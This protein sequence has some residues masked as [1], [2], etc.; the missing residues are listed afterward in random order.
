MRSAVTFGISIFAALALVACKGRVSD[1]GSVGRTPAIASASTSSITPVVSSNAPAAPRGSAASLANEYRGTIGS[2]AIVAR[3]HHDTGKIHGAYFYEKNGV[4]LDLTGT[5][6]GAHLTLDEHAA[7]E[8]T[9]ALSGDVA[10]DGSITGTWSNS[11]ADKTLPLTLAP[12]ASETSPKTALL[13]KKKIAITK[14]V[15]GSTSKEDV[16]KASLEYAEVF[17]LAPD[18]E[19]KINSKLAPTKDEMPDAVC[20][21]AVENE[22]GFRVAHN[23]DGILSVRTFGW[24]TDSQAAHPDSWGS[25]VNVFL[26]DAADVALFGDVLKPKTEPALQTALAV[27]VGVVAARDKWE[28]ADTSMVTDVL[29]T[30]DAFVIEKNGIRVYADSLPHVAWGLNADGFLAPYAKLTSA[31]GRANIWPK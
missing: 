13:F 9:G 29:K 21:H 31:N 22:R 7:K 25:A 4:D 19:A 27:A 10:A 2:I 16:C 20:D 23:A 3:L 17:A 28:P 24:I 12:I 8:N 15:K 11:K 6:E 30:P 26:S 18:V 5:I 14:P 1:E